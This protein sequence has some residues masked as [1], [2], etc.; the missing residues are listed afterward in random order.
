MRSMMIAGLFVLLQFSLTGVRA[1]TT[2]E[3]AADLHLV[4]AE[5]LV[6]EGDYDAALVALNQVVAL[7]TQ[8]ALTIPD[9]FPFIYAQVALSA[10]LLDTAIESVKQYIAAAGSSGEF[11]R[12][13]LRLWDEAEVAVQQRAA[14]LEAQREA[15]ARRLAALEAERQRRA[16]MQSQAAARREAEARRLAEARIHGPSILLLTVLDK[17][18]RATNFKRR[19]PKIR[20][21]DELSAANLAMLYVDKAIQ[22][23]DARGDLVYWIDTFRESTRFDNVCGFLPRLSDRQLIE[24][25]GDDREIARDDDPVVPVVFLGFE[26]AYRFS[27]DHR[28]SFSRHCPRVR[29]APAPGAADVFVGGR[30]VLGVYDRRG[31]YRSEWGVMASRPDHF[32]LLCDKLL[33]GW[34]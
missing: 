17:A 8:H 3:V 15:E 13:A 4:R 12:D 9:D 21:V 23:F 24:T 14:E 19:C 25:M 6:A 33:R 18:S 11:Y 28:R 10:G 29:V 22:L 27:P 31:N 1:Q 30:D 32:P 5:R 26:G 16:E 20:L 2:P 7:Q 34:N